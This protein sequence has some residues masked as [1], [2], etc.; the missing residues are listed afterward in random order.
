MA[1]EAGDLL[2]SSATQLTDQSISALSY[3]G[4]HL[5]GGDTTKEKTRQKYRELR[6]RDRSYLSDPVENF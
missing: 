2:P 4:K 5:K 3:S 6:S 1:G